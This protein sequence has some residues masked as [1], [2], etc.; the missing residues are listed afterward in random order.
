MSI[1]V[2]VVTNCTQRKASKERINLVQLPPFREVGRLAESWQNSVNHAVPISP[3]QSM[4]QGR[5]ISDSRV[6]VAHLGATWF[7]VSAGLGLVRSD[8]IVPAY[9]CT[10]AAGSELD[11]RLK[12]ARA[13]PSDWWN[14][15]TYRQPLPL[16]RLIAKSLTFL[17]LP[18]SYLCMIQDDLA[19][20][21]QACAEQLRIFTSSAGLRYVPKHLSE[22]VMPYDERLESIHNFA[23]T[24]SDFA[25]RALRHFIEA[26]EATKLSCKEAAAVV[27]T[28]LAQVPRRT[29]PPGVRVTDDAIRKV[30]NEQWSLHAGSSTR[31]LRYLRD[32][33]RISCEQKRFSRIW[34]AMATE[35]QS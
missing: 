28:A 30:L 13:T 7:F 9:D 33:A 4:Y 26:L 27:S 11:H 12:L 17:A 31:L 16:S 20:V 15:I 34:Q 23:G 18:S 25:Q 10:V 1:T 35:M 2:A 24:R 3:A 6:A 22:C 14:A 32:D 21:P 19:Q 8:Q 29:R 5:A